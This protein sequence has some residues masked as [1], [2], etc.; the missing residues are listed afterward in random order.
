ME[1]FMVD[2]PKGTKMIRATKRIDTKIKEIF[3]IL[4]SKYVFGVLCQPA[5][6]WWSLSGQCGSCIL[7]HPTRNHS[8][9]SYRILI[10][11]LY[12]IGSRYKRKHGLALDAN[13]QAIWSMTRSGI[14]KTSHREVSMRCEKEIKEKFLVHMHPGKRPLAKPVPIRSKTQSL[15]GGKPPA[16]V[17]LVGH[18]QPYRFGLGTENPSPVL[19]HIHWAQGDILLFVPCWL[20]TS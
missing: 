2:H 14:E 12:G 19:W 11:R 13:A 1:K 17:M 7:D 15:S 4:S 5:R 6:S 10:R 20:P 18:R 8:R 9:R 3:W 16:Y